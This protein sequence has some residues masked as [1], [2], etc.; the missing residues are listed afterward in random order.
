MH[1][2]AICQ[3]LIDQV[4]QIALEQRAQQVLSIHLGIG[5]LSGVEARLLQQA[6][7]VARAGGVAAGAELVIDSLPVQVSCDHCGQTTDA[8]PARLL[9]GACGNWR[10]RLVSGDEMQ[11]QHIELIRQTAAEPGESE[12]STKQQHER[13]NQAS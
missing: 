8:L 3:A 7:F 5:P 12:T 1:E 9:C 10:T 2:L 6:F 4:E 13:V 11:L